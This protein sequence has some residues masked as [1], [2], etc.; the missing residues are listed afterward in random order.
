MLN[1][2]KIWIPIAL[3]AALSLAGCVYDDLP[4][5]DLPDSVEEPAGDVYIRFQMNLSRGGIPG[6]TYSGSR[7]DAPNDSTPGTA[8]ENAVNSAVLLIYKVDKADDNRMTLRDYFYLGSEQIAT[9]QSTDGL[10]VPISAVKGD[11]LRIYVAVNLTERMRRLFARGINGNDAFLASAGVDY[12]DVIDEFVPGCG[13]HQ[14]ALKENTGI[15]MTGQFKT[16]D[17]GYDIEITGDNPTKESAMKVTADVSRIVAKAHVLAD[18]TEFPLST[19]DKVTYVTA[20]GLTE[21]A[22][23]AEDGNPDYTGWIGW[24]RLDSVRYI[25]NGMNRASY[26]FPQKND[27]KP[28][29]T[30]SFPPLKDT[31]MDLVPYYAGD[32]F[33]G[34]SNNYIF[35]SGTSTHSVNIQEKGRHMENVEA[36]VEDKFNKTIGKNGSY[37]ND[38]ERYTKGM[39]CLENYFNFENKENDPFGKYEDAIP[40]VSHIV[41][42][43]KLTPRYIVVLKDYAE[44][45]TGFVTAYNDNPEDTRVKYGFNENDFT[46]YDIERWENLK[47]KYFPETNLPPVYRTDFS[48]IK[49]GSEED[50]AYLIKWSLL[51]NGLWSGSESDFQSDKYPPGTFYVYDTKYDEGEVH[52][53]DHLWTQRY[54]YLTAGAVSKANDENIKIKSY[55]VPHIGGWG[56]Y[57]TYLDQPDYSGQYPQTTDNVKIPYYKSQVTRNTYYLIHVTNFGG[58]GGTMSHPEDIKVNTVAV[59]W[60]YE[61]KGDIYLH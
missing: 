6:T 22:Q 11:R 18:A 56:Y 24:I 39:Y 23:Q 28:D 26:I 32:K 27:I 45:M 50:A 37:G 9:I 52:P 8:A 49:T 29:N 61:G 38:S 21:Q 44:K 43:A 58:P 14:S 5:E 48:I 12:W 19:G 42:A 1:L 40:I 57:F 41:I 16:N 36:F 53:G 17:G 15:P 59:D 51:A 4:E 10:V 3:A 2:L 35:Y 33:D 25:P 47:N 7:A 60:D 46:D 30:A 20:K 31:D 55:S 54:L 13:G 34:Y